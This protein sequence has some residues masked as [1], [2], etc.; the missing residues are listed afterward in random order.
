MNQG[1]QS[2][3]PNRGVEA[4]IEDSRGLMYLVVLK[5][6]KLVGMPESLG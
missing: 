3:S 1:V 4:K 5:I 6:G 2:S